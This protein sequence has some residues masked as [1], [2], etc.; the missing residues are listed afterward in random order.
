MTTVSKLTCTGEKFGIDYIA[1][2]GTL[3][4]HASSCQFDKDARMA[5]VGLYF[6]Q[7]Y[8]NELMPRSAACISSNTMSVSSAAKFFPLVALLSE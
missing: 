7:K 5:R 3:V 2:S 6:S 8:F 4:I 1:Y